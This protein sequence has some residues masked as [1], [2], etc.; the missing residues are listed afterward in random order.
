MT[1]V[2]CHGGRGS[3]SSLVHLPQT[4]IRSIPVEG[5]LRLP[6]DTSASTRTLFLGVPPRDSARPLTVRAIWGR[7]RRGEHVV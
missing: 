4:V 3:H 2:G 1:L 5:A 6:G 7:R